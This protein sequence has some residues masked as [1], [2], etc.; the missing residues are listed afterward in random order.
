MADRPLT[1][2]DK[3][4]V[5]AGLFAVWDSLD[6]LLD[7]LPEADWQS[8]SPLPGWN[9]K[10]VVSHIIGTESFLLGI[11]AP[12]ADV[13][14]STLEHVRNPIGVMNESWVIHLSAESGASLLK[15]FREVTNKRRKALE[16]MSDDDW[17]AATTTPAGPTPTDGSC[18]SAPSTAGCMSRTSV[19]RYSGRRPTTSWA[20]GLASCPSTK[21]RPAW[22]SSWA[23]WPK[24]PTAPGCCSS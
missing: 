2:L 9:V 8:A 14:L 5:L 17:N 12:E 18:G 24:R 13:D 3:S 16:S 21:C 22:V 6:A 19:R 7:G 20:V 15:R 4:D 1:Q 10:A 11:G 23:S